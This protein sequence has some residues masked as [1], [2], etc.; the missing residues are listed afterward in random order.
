MP[1]P[2][3]HA[4][5]G[6]LAGGIAAGS[7]ALTAGPW[8]REAAVLALIGMAP[9]LDFLIGQHSQHTHSLGAVLII[10]GLAFAVA[11][12]RPGIA[13]AA[14]PGR[15]KYRWALAVAAAYGSHI[16]LDALGHDTTPP[17]GVM[18]FWPFSADFYQ[19]PL[20]VFM[21][22]SRRYWLPGFLIH[23]LTAVAWELAVLGPLVTLVWWRRIRHRSSSSS[24]FTEAT[25]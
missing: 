3:G 10:G 24:T 5:G 1:S 12:A 19:S 16:L 23:N 4:L 13:P 14:L 25:S 20:P 6:A 7:A 8:W 9:D 17:L 15:L 22:I 2:L 11:G 18:A 21:A